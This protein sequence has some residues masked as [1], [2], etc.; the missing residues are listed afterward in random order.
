MK[1]LFNFGSILLLY[2][3][4]VLEY[5]DQTV[6]SP[7]GSFYIPAV[8]RVCIIMMFT[9]FLLEIDIFKDSFFVCN[10]IYPLLSDQQSSLVFFKSTWTDYIHFFV[11]DSP[12]I[13][14]CKEK[15]N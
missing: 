8:L 7:S 12:F 1:Y 4:D 13:A 10:I 9:V 6:N 15:K 11:P 14:G 2:K 3:A 5:Y